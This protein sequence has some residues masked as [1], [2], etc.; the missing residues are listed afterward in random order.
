M[1]DSSLEQAW[2]IFS[3]FKKEHLNPPASEEDIKNIEKIPSK[4]D[5]N[6]LILESA[7]N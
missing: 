1:M 3:Q 2:T 5:G 4:F 7:V 6:N